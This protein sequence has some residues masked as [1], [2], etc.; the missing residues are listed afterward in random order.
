MKPSFINTNLTGAYPWDDCYKA[1]EYNLQVPD[2]D[3]RILYD[4]RSAKKM[5]MITPC[6][7]TA[8]KN[9]QTEQRDY[10]NSIASLKAYVNQLATSLIPVLERAPAGRKPIDTSTRKE[11]SRMLSALRESQAER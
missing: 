2:C 5:C 10:A 6:A 1:S 11:L 8:F 3:C 4:D 7:A 9:L